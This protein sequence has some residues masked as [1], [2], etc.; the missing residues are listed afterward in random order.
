M[1]KREY[2]SRQ[3]RLVMFFITCFDAAWLR[4]CERFEGTLDDRDPQSGRIA[5]EK[6]SSRTFGYF[7]TKAE[8]V[9]AVENNC[10]DLHEHLYVLAVVEY[11]AP[12]IH[13][14]AGRPGRSAGPSAGASAGTSA[15][16][17]SL[18]PEGDLQPVWFAW[19]GSSD[20]GKWV[21]IERPKATRRVIN[22]A[23]G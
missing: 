20:N 17:S 6:D 11:I 8:A 22:F 13:A 3:P 9:S 1:L 4:N 14:L 18:A 10:G 19:Q 21:R 15:G 5:Y 7:P 16:Q 2:I 23:L 12:G